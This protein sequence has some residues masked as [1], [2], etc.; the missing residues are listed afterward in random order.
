MYFFILDE[1]FQVIDMEKLVEKVLS[2]YL[3]TAPILLFISLE[4]SVKGIMK[5]KLY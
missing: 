1:R 5:L 3:A 4:I 2:Y